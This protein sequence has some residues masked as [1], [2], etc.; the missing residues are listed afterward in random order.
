MESHREGLGSCSFRRWYGTPR[1]DKS[2]LTLEQEDISTTVHASTL[3]QWHRYRIVYKIPSAPSEPH[4][5][6]KKILHLHI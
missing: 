4:Q 1:Q 6:S 5:A 3:G 2:H